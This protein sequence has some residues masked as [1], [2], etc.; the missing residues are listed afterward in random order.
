MN[1]VRYGNLIVNLDKVLFIVL[2]Y[3]EE[4]KLW[5]VFLSDNSER[6]LNIAFESEELARQFM[7]KFEC[8]NFDFS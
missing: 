4:D 8:S 2:E 3:S 5:R 7:D 6:E 1:L